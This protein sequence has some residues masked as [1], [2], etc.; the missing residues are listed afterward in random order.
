MMLALAGRGTSVHVPLLVSASNSSCIAAM[1]SGSRRAVQ[2][3]DGG[4]DGAVV[5]ATCAYLGLCMWIPSRAHVTIGCRGR[6]PSSFAVGGSGRSSG[7]DVAVGADA[8]V[9]GVAVDAGEEAGAMTGEAGGEDPSTRSLRD[10]ETVNSDR[11]L[12]GK[13]P[14]EEVRA[15]VIL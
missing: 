10:V 4:G 2:T 9:A 8:G 14:V 11:P 15:P 12:A 1:Q 13:R 6:G 3:N 5:V 7:V